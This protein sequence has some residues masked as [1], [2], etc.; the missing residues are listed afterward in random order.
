MASAEQGLIQR[1]FAPISGPGALGIRDHAA[2]LA[3]PPGHDLVVTADAVVAGVHFFPDDAPADIA[4]KAL[5]VNLSD[6]AAKGA[7][8]HGIV[9]TLCLPAELDEDWVAAFADGL[10]ADLETY[11][12]AL[13]GGDTVRAPMLS[14]SITA[15]GLVPTGGMVRRNGAKPSDVL[16]VSGTIGDGALGLLARRGE[17]DESELLDRYL[18]PRPRCGLAEA[19]RVHASA[20]MD[21]SDGLAG[22]LDAL[23][24]ASN[25][26]ARIAIAD[27]PL[28]TAARRIVECDP[29]HMRTVLTGGDDY[30]ILAAV[31][32]DREEAFRQM[33]AEAAVP[34]ARIG[35]LEPGYAPAVFVGPDGAKLDL[36][37]RAYSHL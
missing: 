25:V 23:L 37:R 35:T 13:F 36:A 14:V 30:E 11:G 9:M 21:V 18:R 8:P 15:L 5:R 2:S 28:S 29:A 19:L 12:C 6:L 4:R 31:P 10:G 17:W 1:Y 34:V 24:A 7:T 32:V 27:V 22:D 16:F 3:P 33:A 26:T 20:A